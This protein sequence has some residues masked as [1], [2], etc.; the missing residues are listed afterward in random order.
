MRFN[1]EYKINEI[2]EIK[3]ALPVRTR[4]VNVQCKNVIAYYS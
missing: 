2:E 3:T 1:S 4:I